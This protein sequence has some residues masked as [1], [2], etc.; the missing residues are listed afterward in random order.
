MKLFKQIFIFIFIMFISISSVRYI[1]YKDINLTGK[2]EVYIEG[3]ETVGGWKYCQLEFVYLREIKNGIEDNEKFDHMEFFS[4]TNSTDYD[5]QY[6]VLLV[7]DMLLEFNRITEKELEEIRQD[8]VYYP[9]YLKEHVEESK[10][11]E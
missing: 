4:S 7:V 5:F 3:C 1:Y 6:R 2:I 9:D 10:G 11:S 8:M